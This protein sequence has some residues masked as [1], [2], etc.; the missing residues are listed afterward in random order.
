M[1]SSAVI[2]FLMTSEQVDSARVLSAMLSQLPKSP[3]DKNRSIIQGDAK[4]KSEYTYK[5]HC[6]HIKRCH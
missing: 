2:Q 3:V 5:I 6:V 4:I 1:N